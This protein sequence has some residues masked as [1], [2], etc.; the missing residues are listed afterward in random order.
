MGRRILL[1][2][3]VL[4][5][6]LS[7][8]LLLRQDTRPNVVLIIID[9]LRADKLGAYG[10]PLVT[11]PEL[12]ALASKGARFDRVITQACWTRSSI[13]SMLTSLY[14]R[15]LGIYKERWDILKNEFTTLPE[16]LKGA[17]FHT[18]GVTANPNINSLFNFHQG[19]DFHQD[20]NVVFN[21]MEPVEGQVKLNKDSTPILKAH[22]IFPMVLEKMAQAPSFPAYAQVNIM[23]VHAW[24]KIPETQ[25]DADLAGRPDSRYLQTVRIAS[26]QVGDFVAKVLALPGWENTLFVITSDHGEGLFDHPDVPNSTRH[27][28]VLYESNAVV[29]LILFHARSKL[30]KGQVIREP[31]RML[32]LMPTVLDYIGIEPPNKFDGVS[33]L[34][35]IKN[36]AFSAEDPRPEI[37]ITESTW[38]KNVNKI[39]I[40]DQNWKYIDNRDGWPQVLPRELQRE[41]PENGI[42]TDKGEQHPQLREQ[43]RARVAE[44]EAQHPAAEP[45][46][47]GEGPSPQ[48]LEQLKTLGYLK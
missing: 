24:E 5:S 9:T 22:Q 8:G 10:F 14:P 38:K 11:S 3:L 43:L 15:R 21:W 1:C 2:L 29:P 39:A 17:G 6:A 34:P 19:F 12:D 7:A 32:E 42:R 45:A 48:E 40:Y 35:L 47:P 46:Q 13:G 37:F 25:I 44:W 41:T 23:D 28:N 16:V 30:L 31:V 26:K 4:G 18:L 27:G 33:T 20:S 36:G